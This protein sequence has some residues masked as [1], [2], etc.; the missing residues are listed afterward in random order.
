MEKTRILFVH[1]GSGIGGAPISLLNLIRNLNNSKFTIKVVFAQWSPVVKMFEDHDIKVDVLTFN[2]GWFA[3]AETGLIKWY[4]FYKYFYIWYKW[5]KTAKHSAKQYLLKQDCDIV[6]LNS[7]VLT[8]WA[9]AAHSLGLKVVLHNR[10]S[11]SKGY[12][13]LRRYI[14]KKLIIR[15][16]DAIINISD[17]GRKRLGLT[18]KSHIV[19]NFVNIQNTYRKPF[20]TNKIKVLY[21]GGS[22]R[23]KGFQTAVDCL[24]FLNEDIIVQFAG[25][26]NSLR[27]SNSIKE[28]VINLVKLTIY[29]SFYYPLIKIRNAR[30]VEVIGQLE[31][32]YPYIDGCD[33]LITPFVVEHFSR[34]AIEAFAYGK[35]VIGS[36]V[37]GMDEIVDHGVNGLLFS[38][39]NPKKLAEAINFLVQN[40]EIGRKLGENGRSKA[41]KFFSPEGNTA[42]VEEIYLNLMKDKV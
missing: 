1:H 2:T 39:N 19:Y 6:H 13:G 38:K 35:P 8:S 42:K 15:N 10:E 31:N 20:K 12:F 3:H 21:L 24:P 4:S 36:D 11:I 40:P 32:P 29:R 33:I 26:L 25:S 27:E 16:C 5:N 30:N 34:P 41:E 23:I 9:F 37:G 14:L 17:D 18:T 28:K 22:A 7:H